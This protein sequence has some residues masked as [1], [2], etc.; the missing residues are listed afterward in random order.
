MNNIFFIIISLI[1]I[2]YIFYSIR[3]NKLDITSSFIWI[4]FCII[5]LVLSIWPTSL[6][7]FA[8]LLGITYPPTLF[9]T[10]A[11]VVLFIMIFIQS[12]KIEDL[13]KKVIDLG[14]ELSVLKNEHPPK[15]APK[16]SSSSKKQ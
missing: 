2:I 8:N 4:V 6:D 10:I 7:W 15:T 16:K 13:R 3:K 14:Q 11:I 12:K 1:T 5:L 9:L